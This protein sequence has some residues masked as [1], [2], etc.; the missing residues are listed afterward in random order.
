MQNANIRN[1]FCQPGDIVTLVSDGVHDNLDP[2]W[3]GLAPAM[4]DKQ[5]AVG[6]SSY[7]TAETKWE[8][9]PESDRASMKVNACIC[10]HL[11]VLVSRVLCVHVKDLWLP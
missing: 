11:C 2:Q 3:L 10:I 6:A 8:E 9:I 1:R 4:V 7:I 5:T